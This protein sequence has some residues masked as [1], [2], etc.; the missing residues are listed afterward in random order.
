MVVVERQERKRVKSEQAVLGRRRRR[1]SFAVRMA[2]EL[3][4]LAVM[5]EQVAPWTVD[6]LHIP[7]RSSNHPCR[8][9]TCLEGSFQRG[10]RTAPA[11]F[12]RPCVSAFHTLDS[13]DLVQYMYTGISCTGI[14]V[15]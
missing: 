8:I 5:A 6:F 11:A 13:Y 4:H 15:C 12:T 3:P 9:C 2:G 10:Y 14:L 7:P 1:S